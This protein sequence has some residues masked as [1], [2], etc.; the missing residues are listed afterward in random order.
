L[1]WLSSQYLQI[2]NAGETVEKRETS[3]T[4]GENI[5]RYGH[6]GEQHGGSLKKKTK[7]QKKIVPLTQKSC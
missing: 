4:V 2:I 5:N 1:E 7:K 6:Y 3:S